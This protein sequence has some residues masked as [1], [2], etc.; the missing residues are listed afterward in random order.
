MMSQ[1]NE[2]LDLLLTLLDTHK[3][4]LKPYSCR[5]SSWFKLLNEYNK[6]AGTNFKQPRTL[7]TRFEKVIDLYRTD[8]TKI[9]CKNFDLLS[10]L[11]NEYNKPYRLIQKQLAIETD[12]NSSVYNTTTGKNNRKRKLYDL[13][14]STS[15]L[16]MVSNAK[17]S[18]DNNS[19]KNTQNGGQSNNNSNDDNRNHNNSL[20]HM[21]DTD[22]VTTGNGNGDNSILMENDYNGSHMSVNQASNHTNESNTDNMISAIPSRSTS[23]SNITPLDTIALGMPQKNQYIHPNSSN[24]KN[25]FSLENDTE[26]IARIN[27]SILPALRYSTSSKGTSKSS[28]S[29]NA[30]N[31]SMQNT[32]NLN[33]CNIRTIH[34][35]SSNTALHNI[36]NKPN[37]TQGKNDINHGNASLNSQNVTNYGDTNSEL[38]E[39]LSKSFYEYRELKEEFKMLAYGFEQYS[40]SFGIVREELQ[41]FADSSVEGRTSMVA[42]IEISKNTVLKEI[43]NLK[44]DYNM[45]SSQFR[46]FRQQND[47]FQ[48]DLMNKIDYL[49]RQINR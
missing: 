27:D 29:K 16:Q 42:D 48:A 31:I 20:V 40:Q 10:K 14:G 17:N 41:E 36:A 11:V 34:D 19:G 8:K 12:S 39:T 3:P 4:H 37:D 49:T 46:D 15:N 5:L 25:I 2:S 35:S 28:L 9:Q 18:N 38:L 23:S 21:Q 1:Y 44:A 22:N 47:K 6:T 24:E 45:L 7:K 13:D 30:D 26:E 43:N 32:N 33:N